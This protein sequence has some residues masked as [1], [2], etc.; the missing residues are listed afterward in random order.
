MELAVIKG[1]P[2]ARHAGRALTAWLTEDEAIVALLGRAPV[3]EDDLP[4]LRRRAAAARE[5]LA[6]RPPF[7]PRSPVLELE[8]RSHLDELAARQDLTA[9][10]SALEWRIEMVD[11]R[12]V[13]ALQKTIKTERLAERVAPVVADP[14]LLAEFCLPLERTDAPLG[15]FSDTDKKGFSISSI[16]PN[17][18]IVG[19]NVSSAE[20]STPG[21]PVE[22]QAVTFLV[23]FGSSFVNVAR[24]RGRY[25][26]RDGYH[27]CA[28]LL[29]A[30][31]SRVPCVVYES[32]EGTD[33]MVPGPDTFGEEISFSER[34][35]LLTDFFDPTV[36]DDV[37]QPAL[38]K[39][40]RIRGEEFFVQ[41]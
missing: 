14:G 24:H 9:A 31:V 10:F 19:T 3:R 36:S 39:V 33:Q 2:L 21:G 32:H 25:F 13:Q 41:D 18:R 29:R 27:R 35:P 11:L 12:L 28:A 6:A 30:G 7:E 38:R 26:L 40:L 16:N 15:M 5:E 17:L 1:E 22:V 20:L 4:P 8:D 37:A 23:N 34:P